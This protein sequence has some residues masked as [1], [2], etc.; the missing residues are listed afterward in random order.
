MAQT[1]ADKIARSILA[2]GSDEEFDLAGFDAGQVKQLVTAAFANPIACRE[3]FRIS[4]VVGGGKKVRSKYDDKLPKELSS[5]LSELGFS[6]DKGASVSLACQQSFKYQHN[7]D[8]DLKTMHVFPRVDIAAE[9]AEGAGGEDGIEG[10]LTPERMCT[11]CSM[12]VFG[13]MIAD[14]VHHFSQKRGLLRLLKATDARMAEMEQRMANMEALTPA[15]D[16]LY[17]SAQDLSDKIA[18]LTEQMDAAMRGGKLT[19]PEQA[20]VLEQLSK[21]EAGLAEAVKAAAS[22]KKRTKLQKR[23]DDVS[24]LR[25]SVADAK[26]IKTVVKHGEEIAELTARV[27]RMDALVADNALSLDGMMQ[28]PKLKE[29]LSELKADGG[30]FVDPKM[31]EA[32]PAPKKKVNAKKSGSSG[33]G[34]GRASSANDGWSTAKTSRVGRG[35]GGGGGRKSGGGGGGRFAGLS[36]DD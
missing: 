29:R 23:L 13:A 33:G 31:K 20:D 15:E 24:A 10:E 17:N 16:A 11:V 18:L 7:T 35:G 34:A 2:S 5:A 22:D 25:T 27:A 19:K 12:D 14:K 26:P 21:Q 6:E 30:W 9:E 8:T 3:M 28:L 36:L 4:F 32:L 1:K